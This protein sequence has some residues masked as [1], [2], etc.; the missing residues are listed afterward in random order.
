MPGR[1]RV[2]VFKNKERKE[3]YICFVSK[4]KQWIHRMQVKY[5]KIQEETSV[6]ARFRNQFVLSRE[7]STFW[8][9]LQQF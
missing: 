4:Q 6:T 2:N 3:D 5:G 8:I 7:A 9:H 1:A